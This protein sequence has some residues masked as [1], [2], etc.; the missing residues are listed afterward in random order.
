MVCIATDGQVCG[1]KLTYVIFAT[2]AVTPLCWIKH[3]KHLA[4]VSVIFLI[5]MLFTYLTIIYVCGW[6]IVEGD[7]RYEEVK[8]FDAWHYPFFFGIALLNFEGNP[9]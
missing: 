8:V 9:T 3:M 5:G 7:H 2:L 6:L 1:N 4:Y